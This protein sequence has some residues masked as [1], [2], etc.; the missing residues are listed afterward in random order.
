MTPS[1]LPSTN[2]DISSDL[3]AWRRALKKLMDQGAFRD[4]LTSALSKGP[5]N[6]LHQHDREGKR[7]YTLFRVSGNGVDAPLSTF[8]VLSI[9]HEA[10]GMPGFESTVKLHVRY[11]AE[12]DGFWKTR[13][14]RN[15]EFQAWLALCPGPEY[16]EKLIR[17]TFNE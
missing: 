3:F 17:Q 10:I 15:V 6:P 16:L 9:P 12:H 5:R 8:L 7:H 1:T 4:F 14:V 11:T 13:H 2:I